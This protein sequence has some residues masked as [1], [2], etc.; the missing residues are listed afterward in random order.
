MVSS[1]IL[2]QFIKSIDRTSYLGE[3][4]DCGAVMF[5]NITSYRG[6]CRYSVR[7]CVCDLYCAC[8]ERGAVKHLTCPCVCARVCVRFCVCVATFVLTCGVCACLCVCARVV[9]AYVCA[10][11]CM[12]VHMCVL[13]CVFLPACVL[14]AE[15][16]NI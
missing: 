4:V 16:L 7:A 1:L 14:M 9:C 12:F 2:S 5:K 6:E 13:A 8:A 15:P 11:P 10:F 3:F